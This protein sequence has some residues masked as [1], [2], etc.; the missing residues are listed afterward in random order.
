[1][2]DHVS[3]DSPVSTCKSYIL[4]IIKVILV[5]VGYSRLFLPS[6]S[7]RIEHPLEIRAAQG[8]PITLRD[9][10]P[11]WAALQLYC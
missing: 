2:K 10:D 11:I 4:E 9:N 7:K 6:P 3:D 5:S 8:G 1:M